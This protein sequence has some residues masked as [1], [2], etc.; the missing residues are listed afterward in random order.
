VQPSESEGLSIAL[1][2]AMS[3]RNACL[4]SDI[5]ANLEVVDDIGFTFADRD[6]DNLKLKLEQLL[7]SPELLEKNRENMYNRVKSEYNWLNIA[8]S[9]V[10][11]YEVLTNKN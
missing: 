1:L 7:S 2:E 4:V 3:Y 6:V 11:A 8:D 9:I 10:T 5:P